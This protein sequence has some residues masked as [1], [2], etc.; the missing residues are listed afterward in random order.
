MCYSKKHK[1][2][3]TK[4]VIH[5]SPNNFHSVTKNRKN[6]HTIPR[7]HYVADLINSELKI[8]FHSNNSLNIKYIKKINTM[9]ALVL[10]FALANAKIYFHETFENR[11]KWIDSTKTDKK[12]GPFKIVKGKWY[13]DEKNTGLQTTEDNKFYIACA[14]LDEEFSNKDKTLVVQYNIKFEQKIDCGGGYIKLLPKKSIAK[15]ADF[16]DTSDYNIMF[17]PDICGSSKRTHVI[18]NYKGENHLIEKEIKCESDELSHL[19]T[20]IVKP[21]NTYVVK[22]DGKEKQSGKFDEDWK[23][24]EPKEIDDPNIKKPADWVEE[25]EIDDPED[26]KPEGWDDIPKTIV[27][28]NAQKPEEWDDEDDGEW[29]APVIENPDYKGEWKPKRIPNPAYKGEWVQPRIPN[30]KYKYDPEIYSFDSFAFIGIDVWQ[31]KAG[32]IYD[33]ILITDSEEEAEAEAK[34]ILERNK[35][36]KEMRDKIKEEERKAKEE[37]DKKAKEEEEAKKAEEKHEEEPEFSDDEDNKEE[38]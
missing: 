31:V 33:D 17:G 4:N 24:L 9:F 26:K 6:V 28:P 15:E 2:K 8:H 14:K 25:K 19:Y 22:I 29:E 5:F 21:D 1:K 37:A 38:L 7:H 12:L 20:L 10:L 16:V 34:K 11:D 23:L 27:D 3:K 13:G 30:P 18:M 36:E 32:T 35:A